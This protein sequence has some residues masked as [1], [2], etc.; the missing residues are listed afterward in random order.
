M[1]DA[2]SHFLHRH[3]FAVWEAAETPV[4]LCGE[5]AGRKEVLPQLLRLGLRSLSVAPPLVPQ[6]KDL[7]RSL[8]IIAR[9]PGRPPARLRPAPTARRAPRPPCNCG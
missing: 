3:N 7:V 4:G 5:L 9:S 8:R 6:V 2:Y 1:S